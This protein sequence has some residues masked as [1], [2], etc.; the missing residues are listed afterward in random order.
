MT[1]RVGMKVVCVCD[2][3]RVSWRRRGWLERLRGFRL[4]GHNLNKGDVYTVTAVDTVFDNITKQPM[5]TLLVDHAWHFEL[6]GMGFPSFQFR[7]VVERKT[8]ISIFTE[9]LAPAKGRQ[10]VS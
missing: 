8:D 3:Q 5:Q 9:M 4:L 1:F 2:R 6:R 7:P 10:L